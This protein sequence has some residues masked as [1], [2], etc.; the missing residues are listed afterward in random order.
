MIQTFS[1][2][3]PQFSVV[4]R[5]EGERIGRDQRPDDEK[6]NDHPGFHRALDVAIL[7]VA[8][9]RTLIGRSRSIWLRGALHPDAVAES[10]WPVTAS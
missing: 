7:C 3:S 10:R 9:G 5:G 1:R 8:Y 2:G 6:R 4:R